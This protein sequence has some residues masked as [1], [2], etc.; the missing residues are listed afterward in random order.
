MHIAPVKFIVLSPIE[1]MI[2][3]VNPQADF[4]VEKTLWENEKCVVQLTL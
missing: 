1:A 4:S 2:K 3:G